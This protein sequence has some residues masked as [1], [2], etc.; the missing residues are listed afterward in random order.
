MT[1]LTRVSQILTGISRLRRQ[2]R[3]HAVTWLCV[4]GWTREVGF[5]EWGRAA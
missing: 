5:V 3:P 1:A 4:N 2:A